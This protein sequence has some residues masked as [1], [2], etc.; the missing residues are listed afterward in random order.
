MR[1]SIAYFISVAFVFIHSSS[2]SLNLFIVS[3]E[4][5]TL[6]ILLTILSHISSS[7][8]SRDMNPTLCSLSMFSAIF[9][10]SVVFP[11]PV[12]AQIVMIFHFTAQKILSS[13]SLNPVGI[14]ESFTFHAILAFSSSR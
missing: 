3:E 1:F 2:H 14:M 4:C 10:Q 5:L 11:H 9:S 7:V 13:M 12:L 8:I 6:A